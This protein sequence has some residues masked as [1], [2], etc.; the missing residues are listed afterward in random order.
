MYCKGYLKD[1][2]EYLLKGISYCKRLNILYWGAHTHICLADIYVE[3]GKFDKAQNCHNEAILLLKAFENQPSCL[4]L[5]EIGLARV[6]VLNKTEDVNLKELGRLSQANKLKIL[7]SAFARY[8][9][10]ILINIDSQNSSQ[11]EEYLDKAIEFDTAN[12]IKWNL[13]MDYAVYS[14]LYKQKGDII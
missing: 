2:I 12:G 6:K 8:M 10:D 3:N 11:A 14:D 13:A 1:A 5:H 7:N 4:N 9:S